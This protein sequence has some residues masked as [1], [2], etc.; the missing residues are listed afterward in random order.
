[1]RG[2]GGGGGGGGG[3]SIRRG[4]GM[5]LALE[6]LLKEVVKYCILQIFINSYHVILLQVATVPDV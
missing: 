5:R 6:F 1:M 4:L 3:E 2:G